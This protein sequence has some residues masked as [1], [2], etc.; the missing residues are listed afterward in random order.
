MAIVFYAIL[1]S[2]L[3]DFKST[4]LFLIRRDLVILQTQI[5]IGTRQTKQKA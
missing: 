4:K 1:P 2:I 5:E 3:R